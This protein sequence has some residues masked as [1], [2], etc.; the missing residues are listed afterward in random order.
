MQIPD[1]VDDLSDETAEDIEQ[2]VQDDLDLAEA[3]KSQVISNAIG[4]FTGD[5]I[6]AADYDD[7]DLDDEFEEDDEMADDFD[8]KPKGRKKY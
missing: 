3:I 2:R 6:D 1:N 5:A 8:D 7:D 4:Y